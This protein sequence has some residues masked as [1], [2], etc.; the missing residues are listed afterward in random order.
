MLYL[1]SHTDMNYCVLAVPEKN[2][3][4]RSV[5]PKNVRRHMDSL[6]GGVPAPP[7]WGTGLLVEGTRKE[8]HAWLDQ[9]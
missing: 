9:R 8:I 3:G 7:S 6:I 1:L 2:L 5:L 4:P